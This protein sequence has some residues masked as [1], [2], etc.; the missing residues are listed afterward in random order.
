[1]RGIDVA[2]QGLEPVAGARVAQRL[3]VLPAPWPSRF[4]Q[5]RWLWSWAH[6]GPHDAV[7]FAARIGD[8]LTLCLK[9][10]LRRLIGHVDARAVT[11]NF[12]PWYTQ[13]RPPS[14]LRPKNSDAPRCGQLF[15]SRPD[16]TIGVAERDQVF[17]QQ[18]HAQRVASGLRQLLDCSTGNP[19][20]AHQ[21]AHRRARTDATTSWFVFLVEHRCVPVIK[22][23][24][25]GVR[26]R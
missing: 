16:L 8:G 18:T 12:Q 17:A 21:L 23:L 15:A 14:S 4:G 6:I 3:A 20:L 5:R 9:I 26:N 22:R 10:G 1:M 7:A 25:A 11:S 13:R 24:D 19:V 2:L